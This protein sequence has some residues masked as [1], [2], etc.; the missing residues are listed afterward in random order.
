MTRNSVSLRVAGAILLLAAGWGNAAMGEKRIVGGAE[1][2]V[3]L[4]SGHRVLAKVDTGADT[5]SLDAAGIQRIGEGTGELKK[6]DLIRFLTRSPEG[7]RRELQGRIVRFARIK[8]K[9]APS[10]RR[11]IVEM[12]ICFAGQKLKTEIT[13]EDRHNF[14]FPMLVG[15]NVLKE[16]FVVDVSRKELSKGICPSQQPAQ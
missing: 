11:P 2:V 9:G 4:A 10:K 5:S 7:Q 3:F 15:R 6:G 13:L 14:K 1:W 16:G 8:R 12:D